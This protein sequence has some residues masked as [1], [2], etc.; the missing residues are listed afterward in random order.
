VAQPYYQPKVLFNGRISRF[1][2]NPEIKNHPDERKQDNDGNPEQLFTSARCTSQ[3][4]V[5]G[6]DVKYQYDEFYEAK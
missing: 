3:T 4:I 2:S 5:D 6:H 1:F